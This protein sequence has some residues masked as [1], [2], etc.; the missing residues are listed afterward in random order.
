MSVSTNDK[1]EKA[2]VDAL[3]KF[4]KFEQPELDDLIAKLEWV[5]GSYRYDQNPEGLFEIGAASLEVL[6]KLKDEKPKKVP[7]KLVEDL[8]KALAAK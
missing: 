2:C 8:E 1:I 3:E 5:I 7:K 6:K 4:K